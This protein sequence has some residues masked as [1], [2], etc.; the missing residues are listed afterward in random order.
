MD[1]NNPLT[2]PVG[3]RVTADGWNSSSRYYIRKIDPKDPSPILIGWDGDGGIGNRY[4]IDLP[5]LRIVEEGGG[6][7]VSDDSYTNSKGEVFRVGDVVE[8]EAD[9]GPVQGPI[10]CI[11]GDLICF[12]ANRWNDSDWVED[13]GCRLDD[14]PNHV[15]G[16]MIYWTRNTELL[17][18]VGKGS[19]PAK[20]PVVDYR[21]PSCFCHLSYPENEH[22]ATSKLFAKIL[23]CPFCSL[24]NITLEAASKPIPDVFDAKYASSLK[25][26]QS[27]YG[28]DWEKREEKYSQG[29]V[30][31]KDMHEI[32]WE[33]YWRRDLREEVP[34]EFTIR[35]VKRIAEIPEEE[36]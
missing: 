4:K 10:V 24:G 32:V 36:E 18:L 7:T 12:K 31:N 34:G 14:C 21:C 29:P 17:K 28:Y 35:D 33:G 27:E 25:L 23:Y 5:G 3:T 8:Q 1:K 30:E 26:H 22:C 6:V 15:P 11:H 19:I 2:W 13:R 16:K 20:P 9:D